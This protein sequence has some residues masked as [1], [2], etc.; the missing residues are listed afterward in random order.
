M[1]SEVEICGLK[2]GARKKR[3]I[4]READTKEVYFAL[5]LSV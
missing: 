5:S 1:S 4:H 2:C 3:K